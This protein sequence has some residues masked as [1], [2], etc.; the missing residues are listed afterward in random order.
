MPYLVQACLDDHTLAVTTASA[1]E[2]F[3]KAVEWENADRFNNVSISKNK[4]GMNPINFTIP[5][6]T[7]MILDRVLPYF[8]RSKTCN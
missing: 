7:K 2:A 5:E 1:K 8:W 6:T 4:Y 3:A